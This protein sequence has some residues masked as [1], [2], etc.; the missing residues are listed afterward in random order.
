MSQEANQQPQDRKPIVPVTLV[1]T[2]D[3]KTAR[4]KKASS[5]RN[6]MIIGGVISAIGCLLTF[7]SGFQTLYWGAILFG[8]IAFFFGLAEYTKA[9]SDSSNGI[10]ANNQ[11]DSVGKLE[12]LNELFDS[13]LITEEEFNNKKQEILSGM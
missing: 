2:L 12:I 1:P 5:G 4:R 10:K 3:A 7:I 9:R 8:G 13:G 11:E 6:A